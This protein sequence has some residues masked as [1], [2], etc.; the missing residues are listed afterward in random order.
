MTRAA[1]F[2]WLKVCTALQTKVRKRSLVLIGDFMLDRP[3]D[4]GSRG[5]GTLCDS[6]WFQYQQCILS[7]HALIHLLTISLQ[8]SYMY[9]QLFSGLLFGRSNWDNKSILC[10][11]D[12]EAIMH[13]IKYRHQ[14]QPSCN[15]FDS[16]SLFLSLGRSLAQLI[17]NTQECWVTSTMKDTQV[18]V[19]DSK[20]I[21]GLSEDVKE[22]LKSTC[23]NVCICTFRSKNHDIIHVQQK[24][25]KTVGYM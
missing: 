4:S 13:T 2:A 10:R 20:S 9:F 6:Q 11:C 21:R 19:Y 8:S 18:I 23:T 16:H 24:G 5:W 12:I 17:W 7:R 14:P 15:E 1:S 3:N 25:Q 22:Q